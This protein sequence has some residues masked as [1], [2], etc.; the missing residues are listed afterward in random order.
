MRNK[1]VWMSSILVSFLIFKYIFENNLH[2]SPQEPKRNWP[3]F[4]PNQNSNNTS[5]LSSVKTELNSPSDKSKPK[6]R[7]TAAHKCQ[8]QL[9][10]MPVPEMVDGKIA[11][12]KVMIFSKSY[13]PYCIKAKTVM[14]KY[15][16]DLLSEEDYEVMEIESNPDCQKIQDYLLLITGGKSVRFS[17]K[18]FPD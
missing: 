14:Q 10:K 3:I 5:L 18:Y 16:G 9:T 13:C 11:G 8:S 1:Y 6:T 4:L 2:S 12:K 17:L 15:L 7:V